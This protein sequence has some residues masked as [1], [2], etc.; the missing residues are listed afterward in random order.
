MPKIKS[1]STYDSA[2]S[3]WNAA[4]PLGA[5]DV[6]IDITNNTTQPDVDAVPG[7]SGDSAFALDTDAILVKAELNDTN[8]SAWTKF[9]RFVKR[10]INN[11]TNYIEGSLNTSYNEN[12][13]ETDLYSANVLNN[14]MA[15]VIGISGTETEVIAGEEQTLASAI[16]I[17]HNNKLEFIK[18]PNESTEDLNNY[19]TAGFYYIYNNNST[20]IVSDGWNFILNIKNAPSYSSEEGSAHLL[21]TPGIVIVTPIT[22]I[23]PNNIE[24]SFDDSTYSSTPLPFIAQFYISYSDSIA[25]WK[26]SV[27]IIAKSNGPIWGGGDIKYYYAWS[28]WT[29]Y[30]TP[31]S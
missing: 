21:G 30:P 7:I 18:I 14:Y 13:G 26:R 8:A 12:A 5:D 28:N 6:N 27:Q 1:I 17:L 29:P 31:K 23:T 22:R 20:Y 25:I 16:N 9:N 15:N 10:V 19:Q 4:I 11:F 2:N 24:F 3:K